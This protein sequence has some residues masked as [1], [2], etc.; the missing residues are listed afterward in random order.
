METILIIALF[1]IWYVIGVLSF[2]YVVIQKYDFITEDI[3][4]AFLMGFGGLITL[5]CVL[6]DILRFKIKNK[7]LIRKRNG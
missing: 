1:L 2:I 7:V 5:I 3:P 6:P 4:F